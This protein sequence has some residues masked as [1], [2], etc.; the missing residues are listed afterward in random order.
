MCCC[1]LRLLA[2][3]NLSEHSDF[4]SIG[5]N[6]LAQYT[7]AAGRDNPFVSDCFV[8]NHPVVL[9]LVRII[10]DGAGRFIGQRCTRSAFHPAEVPNA[11]HQRDGG[12][13]YVHRDDPQQ[14]P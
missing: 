9:R 5:T 3:E 11:D 8:S 12:G 14:P 6:D 13:R 10:I 1:S 7:M 2:V 4:F